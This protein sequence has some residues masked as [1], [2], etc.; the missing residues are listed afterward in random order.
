MENL[1]DDDDTEPLVTFPD[2]ESPSQE[3]QLDLSPTMPQMPSELTNGHGKHSVGNVDTVKYEQ[4]SM[5]SASKTKVVTDGYS[6][7][8]VSVF[9]WFSENLIV[10]LFSTHTRP[11]QIQHK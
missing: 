7:E 10:N 9:F 6:S 8:Q 11:P 2:S 1:V 4:K 3:L 5:S